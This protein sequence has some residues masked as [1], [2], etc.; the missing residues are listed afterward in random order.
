MED[1]IREVPNMGLPNVAHYLAT[2]YKPDLTYLKLTEKATK[3]LHRGLEF[4]RGRY[5]RA[6]AVVAKRIRAIDKKNK[7]KK[8][9]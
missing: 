2:T 7:K 8:K 1:F 4:F 9:K 5:N 6:L 3:R